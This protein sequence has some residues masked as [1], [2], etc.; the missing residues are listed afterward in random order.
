MA[1]EQQKPGALKDIL[2]EKQV[3]DMV[4]IYGQQGF[5][6]ASALHMAIE[7]HLSGCKC[8]GSLYASFD[9]TFLIMIG[10][11]QLARHKTEQDGDAMHISTFSGMLGRFLFMMEQGGFD[12]VALLELYKGAIPKITGKKDF[13]PSDKGPIP[14]PGPL[15]DEKEGESDA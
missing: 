14:F 4:K 11:A 10:A 8:L 5:D 12:V 2:S 9:A 6:S 15:S 7:E 3:A 1:E 13:S